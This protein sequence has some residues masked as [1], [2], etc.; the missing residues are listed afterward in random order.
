MSQ[1][2]KKMCQTVLDTVKKLSPG[3]RAGLWFGASFAVASASASN[4]PLALGASV[5]MI[6]AA[7]YLVLDFSTRRS[8]HGQAASA[9]TV[10]ASPSNPQRRLSPAPAYGV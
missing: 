5:S 7:T 4:I 1:G 8:Q 9:S 6:A 2:F 3:Q 10:F